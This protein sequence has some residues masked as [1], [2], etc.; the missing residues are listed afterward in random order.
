MEMIMYPE[1]EAAS[2]Y[3]GMYGWNWSA[4]TVEGFDGV[5]IEGY[6]SFPSWAI[7]PTSRE[8]EELHKAFQSGEHELLVDLL[9]SVKGWRG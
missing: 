6:R 3:D 5:I 9:N 8:L 1:E 7:V 2:L 4:Y